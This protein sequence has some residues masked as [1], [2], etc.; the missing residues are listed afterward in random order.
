MAA[1]LLLG[2]PAPL[3]AGPD[4]QL[5]PQ[6]YLDPID[7][8]IARTGIGLPGRPYPCTRKQRTAHGS[9]ELVSLPTERCV[10]MLPPQRWRGLWRDMFEGSQFCPSPAKACP[11]GK[12]GD[13]IWLTGGHP[14]NEGGLY[15]ITF[16]GRRT[17][18]RGPYGH[19]GFSDQEIVVDRLISKRLLQAPHRPTKAEADAEMKRCQA[20][21]TCF[22]VEQWN[23]MANEK[24]R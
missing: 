13:R 6:A 8:K 4:D 2:M 15:A 23:Q 19:L 11:S 5:P 17:A 22:T 21:G 7:Q 12:A 16:I 20:N 3:L 1:A 10:R 24:P 18:Y 9:T 14:S